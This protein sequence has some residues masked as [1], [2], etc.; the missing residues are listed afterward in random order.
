MDDVKLP[1]C[2]FYGGRWLIADRNSD[3]FL[4]NLPQRCYSMCLPTAV[5]L[6]TNMF[7]KRKWQ[8]IAFASNGMGQPLGYSVR[9]ILGGLFT[10]TI[11]WR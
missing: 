1:V 6:I 8:N 10:V 2:R 11:G 4:S 3:Y 5:S 9:L 7:S